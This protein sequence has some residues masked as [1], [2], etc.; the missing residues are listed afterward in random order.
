MK[1]SEHT[2][3]TDVLVI[4]AGFAGCFAAIRA[5]ELGAKVLI[6]DAG[7]SGFSGASAIGTHITRVVLPDDDHEAALKASVID[8]DYMVDQEYAEGVITE[9][10][11]RFN[12]WLELG[13]NFVRDAKGEID[14]IE[15]TLLT[16]FSN[17]DMLYICHLIPTSTL[18]TLKTVPSIWVPACLTGLW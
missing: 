1:V 8:S 5:R 13:S 11:D 6:V 18:R 2:V 7:K 15:G 10:Y 3:V 4:G 14:W 12:Q 9:S 16:P 17:R